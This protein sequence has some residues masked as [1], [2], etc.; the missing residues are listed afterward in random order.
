MTSMRTKRNKMWWGARLWRK[1]FGKHPGV[2]V[3][4]EVRSMPYDKVQAKIYKRW[5]GTTHP[6]KIK[7]PNAIPAP[8]RLVP[9]D[10]K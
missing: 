7:M 8:V 10:K 1:L 2:Y 3:K 6:K 4:E 5:F 9:N